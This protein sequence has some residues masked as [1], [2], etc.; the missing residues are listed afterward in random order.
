MENRLDAYKGRVLTWREDNGYNDSDFLAL[1]QED[2]GSFGWI[3]YASTRYYGGCF[4]A[5]PDA[6]EQVLAAYRA[7][8]E[9][10]KANATKAREEREALSARIGTPVKITRSRKYKGETGTVKWWGVDQYKSN[11]HSKA[12]RAGVVLD[13]TGEMVFVPAAYLQ[14]EVNGGWSKIAN[15]AESQM[16][17][18]G[19]R[20]AEEWVL[21]QYPHPDRMRK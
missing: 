18:L 7:Y 11:R 1:V 14:V 20:T 6:T 4:A 3:E 17:P 8:W 16:S 13:S 5:K 10:L 15:S 21:S 9:R 19:N 2:D 12:F